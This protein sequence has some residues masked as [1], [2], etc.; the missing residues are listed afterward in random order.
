MKLSIVAGLLSLAFIYQA[1]DSAR[2]AD[3]RLV[4]YSAE[5]AVQDFAERYMR[6]HPNVDVQ[7]LMGSSGETNARVAAERHAP[8]GDV[9]ISG[10]DPSQANPDLYRRVA[11]ILDLSQVD[12]RFISGEF[13]IPVEVFPVIFAYN[14]AQLASDTA[15]STWAELADPKWKGRLYMGNP[16]TSE[17]AYKAMSTMWA[18][19]G[20][21]LVEKVAANA[22]ITEGSQDP[23]RALGDGE[24]TIGIGVEN[25]VYKWADGQAVKAVYPKDG[26]IMH[27]ATWYL[28]NN[29]PNTDGAAAFVQWMLTPETQAYMAKT[30]KGMR[31]SIVGAAEP[32]DVPKVGDL[33]VIPFPDE[34]RSKRAAF[35][36]RWKSIITSIH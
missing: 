36:E 5:E 11:G 13:D 22:I 1:S 28:V 2:A 30:F 9:T 6:E 27:V 12:K 18:I 23:L 14:T 25:Q 26:V 19:G 31:P 29:S 15:P 21:E 33:V 17:A 20:W 3:S 8:Q 4:I 32:D 34:A 35:N 16:A 24:A 10:T 7:V